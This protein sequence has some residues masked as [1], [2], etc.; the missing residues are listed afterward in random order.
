M[1]VAN[2]E[3][4]SRTLGEAQGYTPLPVRYG[5]LR[6][7]DGTEVPVMTTAWTPTPQELDALNSGAS[8]HVHILGTQHPP[9]RLEVGPTPDEENP[10]G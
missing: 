6:Y 9:L 1:L 10:N 3:G 7:E 5:V 2:I 4:S 8:I